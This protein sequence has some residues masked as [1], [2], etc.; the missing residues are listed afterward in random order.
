MLFFFLRVLFVP[1]VF[2]GRRNYDAA[3]EPGGKEV[4]S[5]IRDQNGCDIRDST[6]FFKVAEHPHLV[7]LFSPV[8]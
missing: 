1:V 2:E 7:L 6:F 8:F 5:M 4:A 3:E